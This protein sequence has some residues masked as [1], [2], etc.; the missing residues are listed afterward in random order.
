VTKL[1]TAINAALKDSQ[2]QARFRELQLITA[3]GS[4]AATK[5]LIEQE[6]QQWGRVVT[7]AGI[8]PE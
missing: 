1:N 5:A 7:A 3:G 2:V 4:P 8:T 6:R